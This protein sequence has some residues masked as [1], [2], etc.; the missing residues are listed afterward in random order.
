MKSKILISILAVALVCG[1]VIPGLEGVTPSIGAGNGL[2]ITSFSVEPATA[3]SKSTVRLLMETENRG[4]T[5]VANAKSLVYLTG[6]NFADWKCD[7]ATTSYKYYHFGKDMKSEDIVRGIP[8]DTKRF[9]WSCTAPEITPGQ[10]RQDTFIGR[11][12]HEYS[13]S[14]NGNVW[15]YN[16]TEA[17]AART[18]GRTIYTPSFTYT[19]GPVGLQVSVSPDPLILYGN[20]RNFTL[21]V[22]LNNLGTGTIYYP[23]SVTYTSPENVALTPEQLNNVSVSVGGSSKLVGGEDCKGPQEL[24]AGRETTL[25][26]DVMVNEMVQTFTSYAL[27][28]TVNY[29][30]Y[31]ER[32]ATVTV[33]G[34]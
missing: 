32:T 16:E 19:R 18:A 5:N 10:T 11:I 31:T 34:R 8:A 23:G 13:T 30:Y 15:V 28:V 29:G 17:E 7:A 14:A 25:V 33:Q 20:E 12:Y 6:S 26:C 3:F 2:E 21:Y 27:N 4:G 24:V 1:C 22:K 9:S